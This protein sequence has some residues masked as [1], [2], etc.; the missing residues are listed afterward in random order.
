MYFFKQRG[1]E[2]KR[3]ERNEIPV[4]ISL[5]W[6]ANQGCSCQRSRFDSGMLDSKF[7]DDLGLELT[8]H[9]GTNQIMFPGGKFY[10]LMKVDSNDTYG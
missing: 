6:W 2:K 7:R 10:N 5:G 4:S 3:R 8:G 9:M 1:L